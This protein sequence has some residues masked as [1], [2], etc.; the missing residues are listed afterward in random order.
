MILPFGFVATRLLPMKQ[1]GPTARKTKAL[2][3]IGWREWIALP[4]LDIPS[5]KV[6]VDTGARSSALHAVDGGKPESRKRKARKQQR[7][8]Q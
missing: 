4:E 6:K 5:I 8:A 1:S 3:L 2:P 7:S